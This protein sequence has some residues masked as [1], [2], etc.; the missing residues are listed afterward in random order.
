MMFGD[1]HKISR[2]QLERQY[3]LTFLAP[4]LLFASKELQGGMG[5]L[6]VIITMPLVWLALIWMKR[7]S[8]MCRKIE[9][10]MG[11]VGWTIRVFLSQVFLV[12][13]G[14]FVATHAS[15]LI[16]EY[17]VPGILRELVIVIF[18]VASLTLG[19]QL[20]A[21]G[22]FAE[23]AW[24]VVSILVGIFFFFA[25]WQGAKMSF[26]DFEQVK[27]GFWVFSWSELWKKVLTLFV[28]MAG[29]FL[30]SFGDLRQEKGDT[31]N[32]FLFFMVLK[33]A[34]WLVLAIILQQMYFGAHG[35]DDLSYPLLDLMSGVKLPGNF[36][37]RLDLIFLTVLLFALLFTMGSICFYSGHLWRKVNIS[38]GRLP[39][40]ALIFALVL[41]LSGC[42]IVEPEKRAYP[43]VL[44]IDWTGEEYAIYLAMAKMAQ[45][46]GQEKSGS[47][48]DAN[49]IVLQG[50]DSKEIQET[51]DA[52]EE[53]Y[54]DVGHV[55][56]LVFGEQLLMEEERAASILKELEQNHDLG[57]SPYV[58]QTDDMEGLFAKN[59]KEIAS[60]GDYLKGLYE[61]RMQK[62][63][64]RTLLDVYRVLHNEDMLPKIP[65][66]NVSKEK[67]ELVYSD[68]EAK[69]P[70]KG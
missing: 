24:P 61:N 3:Q 55:Q 30:F 10:T 48:Q 50:K 19:S 52:S 65:K 15:R 1:N 17:M 42:Q 38:M 68:S 69:T 2:I 13:A 70:E 27:S 21:R 51:Y 60:L 39:I 44:G 4:L 6:A 37:R 43:L 54:L 36:V 64:P 22:R 11:R 46:T 45:S 33:L 20:E 12:V 35:A 59:G 16:T 57:N 8:G 56:A 32:R 49:M 18:V 9:K 53:L 28:F 41:T 29:T 5:I 40:V 26:V 25:F 23:I 67:V 47:E 62:R 66:L 63:T 34:I 14:V 7:K 31:Q 58:F